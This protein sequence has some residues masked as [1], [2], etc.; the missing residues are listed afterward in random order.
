[1]KVKKILSNPAQWMSVI[2]RDY[3][4]KMMEEDKEAFPVLKLDDLFQ[5]PFSSVFLNFNE[6]KESEFSSIINSSGFNPPSNSRKLLGDLYYL[7]IKTLEEV[8]FH[9][10]ANS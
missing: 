9:V 7:Q 3:A 2:S 5:D 1:M 6:K 8:D 4:S 10:T